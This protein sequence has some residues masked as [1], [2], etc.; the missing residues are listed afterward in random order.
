MEEQTTPATVPAGE[1]TAPVNPNTAPNEGQDKDYK[2]MYENM[3]KAL[4]EERDQRK[5][6]DEKLSTYEQKE[7]EEQ[8]KAMKAK[9]KFE[10]LL[11]EKEKLLN[12]LMP[13]AKARDDYLTAKEQKMKEQLETMDK[14]YPKELKE[15]YGSI[16]E[17]LDAEAKIEFMTKTKGEIEV[18]NKAKAYSTTPKSDGKLT[19]EKKGKLS[20]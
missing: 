9:G 18:E 5:A 17:K 8:E 4:K 19:P 14:E 16:M 7:K 10:E 12:D 3:Q 20:I 15:K 2:T 11:T 6:R 1:T 13:K